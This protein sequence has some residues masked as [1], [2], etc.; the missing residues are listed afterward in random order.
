MEAGFKAAKEIL[1]S[2]DIPTRKTTVLM[3]IIH[4]F[5]RYSECLG[6]CP[7]VSTNGSHV[8]HSLDILR[9]FKA[10]PLEVRIGCGLFEN[11]GSRRYFRTIFYAAA[12]EHP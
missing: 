12:I 3:P 4:P 8:S 7:S 10:L 9:T 2:T 5:P 6:K 1:C 11:S